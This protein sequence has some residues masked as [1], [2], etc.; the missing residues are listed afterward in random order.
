MS[1]IT[2][3]LIDS[4]RNLKDKNL[5]TA[6]QY[7]ECITLDKKEKW[8]HVDNRKKVKDVY[9]QE[10]DNKLK[11]LSD[12]IIGFINKKNG[13]AKSLQ[14]VSYD[15]INQPNNNSLKKE[16][17]QVL[18]TINDLMN[19]IMKEK[20]KIYDEIYT[21]YGQREYKELVSKYQVV[22]DNRKEEIKMN[23]KINYSREKLIHEKNYKKIHEHRKSFNMVLIPILVII[24][25]FLTILLLNEDLILNIFKK[26][27]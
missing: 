13:L 2:K 9:Q 4:C 10:I 26:I 25:I 7:D 3:S 6:K 8:I 22:E 5:I 11:A 19:Q 15:L 14:K 1:K 17:D 23:N 27:N 16:K 21:N 20:N 12:K 24:I 18:S